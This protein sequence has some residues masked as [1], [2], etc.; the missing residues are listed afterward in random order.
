MAYDVLI[1]ISDQHS[2]PCAGFMGDRIADTPNIDALAER[3]FSFRNAYTSC[4][5]CVPAR[6][7]FMT[8]RMPSAI[9][10]FDNN[11]DYKSS[12]ISFAHLH[13]IAGYDTTL[14][15][16]MH[17]MGM[18]HFHGFTSRRSV[19]FSPSYWG[20]PSEKREDMG[21]FGRSLYQKWC[22]E[23]VGE[24]DSPVL[25][26]DRM[27]TSEALS[28]LS[29]DHEAPQL[30][31]VGTYAPHFPYVADPSLMEKYRKRLSQNP[32]ETG[33]VRY[34]L[35]SDAKIQETSPERLLEIRAAYYAMIETM[36]TQIGQ[37]HA[38]FEDYLKRTGHKG[39]F[40]YMSDHGDQIGCK[41]IFG[42][43]TFFE[44]SAKIPLVMEISD[45]KGSVIEESVSIMDIG[46]SLCELNETEAYPIS[47]GSSFVPLLHGGKE[48]GRYA[49]S[50]YYDRFE[51]RTVTGRMMHRDG[52]KLISYDGFGQNDLLFHTDTDPEENDNLVSKVPELYEEMKRTMENDARLSDRSCVFD[53]NRK[54]WPLL[55]RFGSAYISSLNSWSYVVPPSIRRIEKPFRE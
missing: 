26:Y 47:D 34:G 30:V 27:I 25:D 11:S 14:I 7:S 32:A 37:V 16:R 31:V 20:N 51:G 50:E 1:Y 28:F 6:A 8:S 9:G 19:D 5:L 3:G 17:F 21:E 33:P 22:L 48:P 13:A 18:D 44:M 55:S 53:E 52:C 41:G 38:A 54:K 12:E 10:V 45:M 40:I 42:K 35:P 2:G 39:I 4:P 23:A 24:G 15:G 49:V 43:Q 46:P 29:E 36:D